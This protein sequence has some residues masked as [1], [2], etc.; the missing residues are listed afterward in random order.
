[1]SMNYYGPKY[2]AKCNVKAIALIHFIKKE[3]KKKIYDSLHQILL[4]V[5]LLTNI[6]YLVIYSALRQFFP[7]SQSNTWAKTRPFSIEFALRGET[8]KVG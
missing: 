6:H 2:P 8:I 1:M 7:Y 4:R 3:K 5:I